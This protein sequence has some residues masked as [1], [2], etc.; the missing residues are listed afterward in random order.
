ML[1]NPFRGFTGFPLPFSDY[2]IAHQNTN[3]KHFIKFFQKFFKNIHY[4]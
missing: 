2:I 4:K 1:S 3:V